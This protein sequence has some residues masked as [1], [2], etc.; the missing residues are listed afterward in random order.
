MS[1][2]DL[3]E[4]T[5]QCRDSIAR[6]YIQ[7]SVSTYRAGAMRSSIVATWNAI[8]FDFLHKLRELE[9]TGDKNARAKL[10][11]FEKIRAGGEGKL[12]DALEF[13]RSV[14]DVA[15]KEFEL[16]TPV[17]LIDLGRIQADRNRCAHPSMQSADEP[18]QPSP[19]LA[20]LHLRNAVEILLSREP[21]QGKSAFDRIVGEIK[22]PYFPRSVQEAKNHFLAGPLGRARKVLVTSL[23]KGIFKSFLQDK[24]PLEERSRQLAA[25]G[26]ILEMYRAIV[27]EVIQNDLP[28]VMTAVQP[29]D[30]WRLIAVFEAFPLAWDHAGQ[31]VQTTVQRYLESVTD[32]RFR[33]IAVTAGLAVPALHATAAKRV[34]E[35]S[36]G[37]L[38]DL[39]EVR[40][41]RSLVPAAIK[42]FEEADSYRNAE[43]RLERLILPYLPNLTP[44]EI[45]TVLVATA[46]NGQ[47]LNAGRVASLLHKLF[48]ETARHHAASKPAWQ[49]FRTEIQG[50]G[51]SHWSRFADLDNAMTAL[52]M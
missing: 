46:S 15:A 38:G 27:E 35:L 22:S 31:A 41:D 43:S 40:P 50:K 4:L 14:L 51:T 32:P 16:L 48:Q 10:A 33:P 20:R 12:K 24:L 49:K 29:Q 30:L 9:L 11:E 42:L 47:I 37:E 19:E 44:T 52:G 25:L 13:E 6:S 28:S 17:E 26:A 21:V 5:L 39:I 8:V 36:A 23:T 7:E 1:L 34:T 18:Y 45:E 3:D 2:I